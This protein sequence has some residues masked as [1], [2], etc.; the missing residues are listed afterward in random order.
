MV[1]ELIALGPLP[2]A[3][4]PVSIASDAFPG[5]PWLAHGIELREVGAPAALGTYP[6]W[7]TTGASDTW[8]ILLHG[9]AAERT[10]CLRILPMFVEKGHST[11]TITYRN[12]EG[13]PAN[14]SG[15]YQFG[16]DEWETWKL[17]R[18]MRWQRRPPP[19]PKSHHLSNP[20]DPHP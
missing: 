2:Q 5:Y 10:E 12:D 6:A 4:E 14:P 11:L 3:G 18:S 17:P 16:A 15:Y 20:I 19:L 9:M 1:R 13:M 8:A 7:L